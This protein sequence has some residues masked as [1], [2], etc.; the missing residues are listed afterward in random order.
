VNELVQEEPVQAI[1]P[2]RA[3][4]LAAI[5]IVN[6]QPFAPDERMRRILTDAARL[7]AGMSRSGT[8]IP[9]SQRRSLPPPIRFPELPCPTSLRAIRRAP[10]NR[11]MKLNDASPATDVTET[12]KA[13][14]TARAYSQIEGSRAS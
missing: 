8:L 1:D 10:R 4:Q 6:G 14:P 2:E 11:P 5:G 3:G 13:G 12:Q 9:R 7:G